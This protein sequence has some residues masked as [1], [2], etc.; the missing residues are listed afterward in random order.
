MARPDDRQARTDALLTM[1][2]LGGSIR[3][4]DAAARLGVAEMTLRRDAAR[5]GSPLR[6][7]GGWLVPSGVAPEYDLRAE[8]RRN[9]EAKRAAARHALDLIAPGE[10]IFLDCG[11]TTPHLAQMLPDGVRVV[12]HSLPV[13]RL[14]A[15]RGGWG[16]SCWAGHIIHNRPRFTR[17]RRPGWG[18]STWR[19]CR[20]GG[21]RAGG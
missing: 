3:L 9:A 13:A 8:T 10:R 7:L 11:T 20:P 21:W 14:L 15:A 18:G 6:C 19:C 5:P 1:T 17:S 16:S 12:T 2:G 4:R